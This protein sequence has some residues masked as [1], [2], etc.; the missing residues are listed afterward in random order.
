[1]LIAILQKRVNV[2]IQGFEHALRFFEHADGVSG[3]VG[4][5]KPND[6]T[7]MI[8]PKPEGSLTLQLLFQ[9]SAHQLSDQ[10]S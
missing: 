8:L 6:S 3:K 9:I 10:D 5:G 2:D 1:M 7:V 4:S